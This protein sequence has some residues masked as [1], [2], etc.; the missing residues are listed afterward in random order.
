MQADMDV[1]G[2]ILHTWIPA[3]H[4]GKT[5]LSIFMFVGER[6]LMKHFV[7]NSVPENLL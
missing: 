4:A 6:K 1:S 7:V 2:C 5:K 3:I